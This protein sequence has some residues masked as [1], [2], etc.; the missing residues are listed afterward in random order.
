[1]SL[2]LAWGCFAWGPPVVA[3]GGPLP[4]LM[5][6]RETRAVAEKAAVRRVPEVA[7]LAASL[8]W[9]AAQKWEAGVVSAP[10]RGLGARQKSQAGLAPQEDRPGSAAVWAHMAGRAQVGAR[11]QVQGRVEEGLEPLVFKEG[12]AVLRAQAGRRPAQSARVAKSVRAAGP[13]PVAQLAGAPQPAQGARLVRAVRVRAA[14]GEGRAR[15]ACQAQGGW[16]A[17]PQERAGQLK[18]PKISSERS[19]STDLECS[20]TS[21]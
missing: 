5:P 14:W 8:A 2:Q 3:P 16:Q 13:E 9:P 20:S 19:P 21:E 1:M 15:E 17:A 4:R 6:H 18:T 7:R 11:A 10:R 12:Q